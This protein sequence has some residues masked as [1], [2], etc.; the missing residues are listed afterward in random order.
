VAHGV[1]QEFKFC[2]LLG[3]VEVNPNS[4]SKWLYLQAKFTKRFCTGIKILCFMHLE[5]FAFLLGFYKLYQQ[6]Q[7]FIL[8]ASLKFD[9]PLLD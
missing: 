9:L 8:K 1:Y 4:L 2:A 5:C 7:D 6:I 3:S